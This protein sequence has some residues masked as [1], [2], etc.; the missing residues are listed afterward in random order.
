[1]GCGASAPPHPP[2]ARAAPSAAFPGNISDTSSTSYMLAPAHSSSDAATNSFVTKSLMPLFQL[3]ASECASSKPPA[4]SSIVDFVVKL[5]IANKDQL[6]HAS[7][8]A[9]NSSPLPPRAPNAAASAATATGAHVLQA[10]PVSD[11]GAAK[12]CNSSVAHDLASMPLSVTAGALYDLAC[13]RV[14]KGF[15]RRDHQFLHTVCVFT[16]FIDHQRQQSHIFVF[17]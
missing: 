4:D 16:W 11:S 2:A 12:P 6:D 10:L 17:G 5:L 3:I 8:S 9:T 13:D 14:N 7:R 15:Q 1:M